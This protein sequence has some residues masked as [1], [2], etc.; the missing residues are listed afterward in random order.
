MKK[1][2][3]SSAITLVA[4]I[5]TVIVMMILAG[6]SVAM[7]INNNIIS[8]ANSAKEQMNLSA[9]KE[10]LKLAVISVQI[11]NEALSQENLQKSMDEYFGINNVVV[12]EKDMKDETFIIT[13][14][15]RKYILDKNNNIIDYQNTLKSFVD[16]NEIK[17]GDYIV[18]NL[19][20]GTG[21]EDGSYIVPKELTGYTENQTF[22]VKNYIGKW[23]ILYDG[24]EGYGVQI[25]ST[26]NVLQY[27]EN[28]TLIIKGKTGYNN[29]VQ[30]L[31]TVSNHYKNSNYAESARSLGSDPLNPDG[32]K[33]IFEGQFEYLKNRKDI[34][35]PDEKYVEDYGKLSSEMKTSPNFPIWMA[36]R[37]IASNES[38]TYL[39]GRRIQEDGMMNSY[40][41]YLFQI[42]NADDTDG[43]QKSNGVRPVIKLKPTISV[44]KTTDEN[45]K[46]VWILS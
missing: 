42:S 20:I 26:E 14:S 41:M 43:T 5:I 13:I 35:C 11:S 1:L 3:S 2:K 31:N 34:I 29:L 40:G 21:T 46:N 37:M 45:G 9:E 32:E 27:D 8:R 36:A 25:V 10:N 22:N 30:T 28:N 38:I 6:V 4:L 18:Y 16:N 24:T 39:Y 23:Q 44:E 33:N 12:S 19:G 17:K 7:F 15:E